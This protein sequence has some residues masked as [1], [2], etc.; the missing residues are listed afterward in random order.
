MKETWLD[1]LEDK[2]KYKM[3][4]PADFLSLIDKNK[5]SD[6]I[7]YISARYWNIQ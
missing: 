4:T 1:N 3:I 6:L 2:D 7:N 5:Y